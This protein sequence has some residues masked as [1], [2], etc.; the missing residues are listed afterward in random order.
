MSRIDLRGSSRFES[1]RNR[2]QGSFSRQHR[3]DRRKPGPEK[4]R[5]NSTENT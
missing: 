3:P 5:P 4:R 1:R 2:L